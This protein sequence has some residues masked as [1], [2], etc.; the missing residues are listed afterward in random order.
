MA[1]APLKD[2][3]LTGAEPM[4]D[5][6]RWRLEV[7]D[8]GRHIWR[9]LRTEEECAAR[10]QTALDKYWL[11]MPLVRRTSVPHISLSHSGRVA[12]GDTGPARVA[13]G[14]DTARRCA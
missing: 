6:T 7:L 11:G 12:Y 5:Y 9:Y 13:Q 14:G 1:Y 4:T 3:P 10:P 2:V 8:D